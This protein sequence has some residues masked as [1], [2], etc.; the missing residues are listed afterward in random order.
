MKNELDKL[1]KINYDRLPQILEP[2]DKIYRFVGDSGDFGDI[3]VMK[4]AEGSNGVFFY[5]SKDPKSGEIKK[6]PVPSME[7]LLYNIG[8]LFEEFRKK[9]NKRGSPLL[10][11]DQTQ[12]ESDIELGEL[13]IRWKLKKKDGKEYEILI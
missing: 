9:A 13:I 11:M 6:I 12:R 1:E 4:I 8:H 5:Y 7:C 10:K 2:G 3:N